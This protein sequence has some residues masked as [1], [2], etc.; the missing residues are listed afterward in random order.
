[1]KKPLLSVI[2]FLSSF[3][4]LTVS[5]CKK[6]A[7]TNS[8]PKVTT[9][10]VMLDLTSTSGQSGG[11]VT[12]TGTGAITANGV[13]YSTSDKVP[14]L[15]DNKTTDP[16]IST[17]YNYTSNITGLTPGTTYYLRAYA[18]NAYGT[19]YGATISFSTPTNLSGV[20]GTVTTFAGSGASGFADGSG[21]G[22]QFSNPSGMVVD[23]QGN[24]YI[25]DTFNNRIRKMTPDGTVTTVAGNGTA[26]HVDA[27]A[28]DA[29]F[30]APQGLAI[31]ASGNI[32]VA[33]YGNNVI[34][35]IGTDG[36]VST[37]AGN[38]FAAFADGA[39]LK[40]AAFNGPAG[41]A[42]DTKGNLFVADEN[43]DMIRKITPT[44]GVSLVAGGIGGGYLNL[45]VDSAA[46][47]WG[48]F[49]KPS[50]LVFDSKGNLY[51][52]DQNNSAIRQ[53]TPAG[54]ITTIAGGKDQQALIGY[55]A[56]ICIDA[57]GNSFIADESG[58][59][60]E[61][62]ADKLLYVLAGGNNVQGY[63]D[64]SGSA[65][66][67]NTPMGICVDASGNIYVADFNNNRIR[68]V[69]VVSNN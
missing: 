11:T 9:Q 52:T 57:S 66:L 68:K 23:A 48:A 58:R 22:A 16:V 59:I 14:T 34:R 49:S 60:I 44:G 43:N 15:A 31:D 12:S 6:T 47:S 67:F 53:I 56:A 25:S 30:Y 61:L 8:A 46:N 1:M 24:V 50:G 32:F 35:K 20:S 33:D 17:T 65:A 64:G 63:A 39:A 45:T 54:V 28:A 7:T 27:D 62:T 4:L 37:Y 13:V 38:G 5:S 2:I 55:P 42:F 18:T 19:S 26:G 10:D 29:E 21:T 41:L 51:V 3:A 36:M 69:T 40:V